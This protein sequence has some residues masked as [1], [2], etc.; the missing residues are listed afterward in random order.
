MKINQFLNLF[1]CMIIEQKTRENSSLLIPTTKEEMESEGQRRALEACFL[2]LAFLVFAQSIRQWYVVA[3]SALII[4]EQFFISNV[5]APA[6][7]V[8]AVHLLLLFTLVLLYLVKR[9]DVMVFL[10]G[11]QQSESGLNWKRLIEKDFHHQMCVL[12][13]ERPGRDPESLEADICLRFVN[14]QFCKSFMPTQNEF[15]FRD[16]LQKVRP[17]STNLDSEY[18]NITSTSPVKGKRQKHLSKLRT[19][20]HNPTA[21]TCLWN[22]I[23]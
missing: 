19:S 20:N 15:H 23:Q 7:M 18:D 16:F 6:R 8:I 10:S 11:T 4:F 9:R 3:I 1:I 13:Q 17:S 14:D 21:E 22:N 12:Q 2:L 5:A